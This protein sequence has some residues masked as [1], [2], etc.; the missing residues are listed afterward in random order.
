M[1]RV[2]R[3]D[4]LF[5]TGAAAL[6][7]AA[8]RAV[9]AES[10]PAR[11]IR[12]IVPYPPGSTIDLLARIIAHDLSES[13]AQTV[14]VEN[15]PAGSARVGTTLAAKASPD[16]YT[17][18]FVTT[19][20]VIDPSLNHDLPYDAVKD[21]SPV[22]LLATSPHVLTINPSVPAKTLN[23]F[24]A[25]IKANP[26]KFNRASPGIASSGDLS[27]ELFRLSNGLDLVRVPFNGSPPAIMSTVA[28]HTTMAFTS[29][30]VAAPHIQEGTLRALVVTSDKRSPRFPDVPTMSESGFPDQSSAFMQAVVAPA[31]TPKSVIEQLNHEI[32]R[33]V[34]RPNVKGQLEQLDSEAVTMS[35]EDFAIHIRN[36]I[37]RWGKVI[38]DAKLSKSG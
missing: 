25:L 26:G 12:A 15:I 4:F 34:T 30:A 27:G 1:K 28:G 5:V 32:G 23:E 3:R 2:L 31:G 11:A 8:I 9:N 38:Q 14:Y 22:S 36:E 16:G 7:L 29:L 19:A 10:Y 13:L 37:A 18:L 24:I 21:F 35:P 17:I 33:I 6:T 20:F